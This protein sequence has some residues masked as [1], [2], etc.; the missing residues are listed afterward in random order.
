MCNFSIFGDHISVSPFAD[1]WE[2]DSVMFL[3][4]SSPVKVPVVSVSPISYHSRLW[5]SQTLSVMT[6]TSQSGIRPDVP[7]DLVILHNDVVHK[8]TAYT[9]INLE[10][11][12]HILI[13]L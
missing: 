13:S 6:A 12:F 1:P 9:H 10:G 11:S 3:L 8:K 5:Q 4:G 2:K 7:Y